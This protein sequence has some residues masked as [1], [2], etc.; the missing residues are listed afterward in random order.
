MQTLKNVWKDSREN[1]F[2]IY[3]SLVT[4]LDLCFCWWV[5]SLSLSLLISCWI[6]QVFEP[7]MITATDKTC[8]HSPL[9][10]PVLDSKSAYNFLVSL[11]KT[12]QTNKKK[13]L[14]EL[15]K[16]EQVILS[17]SVVVVVFFHSFLSVIH[18]DNGLFVFLVLENSLWAVVRGWTWLILLA[19]KTHTSGWM[20]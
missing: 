13:N 12:R 18:N 1:Q 3:F 16:Q 8:L 14:R 11:F 17:Y 20:G 15:N 4:S 2:F 6:Q 5:F 19:E 7:L 10:F 9:F